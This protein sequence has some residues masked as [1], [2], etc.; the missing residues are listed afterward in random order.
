MGK[1]EQTASY[2]GR[3]ELWLGDDKVSDVE[4]NLAS[5]IDVETVRTGNYV[6][7][8]EGNQSWGGRLTAGRW[9]QVTPG[10]RLELRLPGGRSGQVFL[11]N[12]A[13]ELVGASEIPFGG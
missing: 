8:V 5:F 1:M 9:D 11:A 3:A 7:R 4:V 12:T 13:G 2:I 6:E 10:E